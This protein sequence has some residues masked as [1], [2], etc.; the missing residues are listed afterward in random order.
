MREVP[1]CLSYVAF[2]VL[3]LL[4]LLQFPT[5][6]VSSIIDAALAPPVSLR[7]L[8]IFTLSY[9]ILNWRLVLKI[10]KYR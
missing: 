7:T 8:Q 4:G 5:N 3:R 1:Y 6:G 9:H 2:L 10:N